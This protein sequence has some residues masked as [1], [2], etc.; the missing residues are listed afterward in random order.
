MV[1]RR[2]ILIYS[3]LVLFN[4]NS[5]E[6]IKIT[7][8]PADH[9]TVIITSSIIEEA[10][11]RLNI[12]A[13]FNY[14]SWARSLEI[15][16]SGDSDAELCRQAKM[17]IKYPN[18]VMVKVP[19]IDINLAVF[20]KDK[21]IDIED[22][23]DLSK[24]SIAYL[25]GIKRI[26]EMTKDFNTY[27]MNKL[28]DAFKLLINNRVDVVIVDYFNGLKTLNKMGLEDIFALKGTLEKKPLYHYL[29]KKNEDLLPELE[30]ILLEMS[31]DG[32]IEDITNKI[33]EN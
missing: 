33:L 26:E 30:K 14:T 16:N 19:L 6:R 9:L 5:L 15:V 17:N 12:I 18:L 20:S 8:G 28:E 23:E 13:D 1:L 27:P 25:R 2:V 11:N 10:Y 3:L 32:T 4:L 29:H 31:K 7:T 22:W 21:N 24:C